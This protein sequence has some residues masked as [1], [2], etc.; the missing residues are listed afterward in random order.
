M[1]TTSVGGHLSWFE[2]GGSRW[3]AKVVCLDI[4]PRP[5]HTWGENIRLMSSQVAEFFTKFANEVVEVNPA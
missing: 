2:V 1:V 5:A 4:I 3:F